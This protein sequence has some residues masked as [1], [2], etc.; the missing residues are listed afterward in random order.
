M[1][2][3]IRTCNI[4]G[5]MNTDIYR[6]LG[7][8]SRELECTKD[9]RHGESGSLGECVIMQSPMGW[10]QARLIRGSREIRSRSLPCSGG[11]VLI[12]PCLYVGK[13]LN[14]RV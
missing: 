7:F 5:A 1:T 6:K 14:N 8:V 13:K 9:L 4:K 11:T 2:G 3:K 10:V 12:L